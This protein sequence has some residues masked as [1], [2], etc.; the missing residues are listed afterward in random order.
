MDTWEYLKILQ[1][2]IHSA[3]FATIGDDDHPQV[4][5]IDIMLAG[6]DSLFFITAKGK[7]FYHSLINQHQINVQSS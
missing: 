5:I 4:R 1:K 3:A 6:E 7:G 2:D